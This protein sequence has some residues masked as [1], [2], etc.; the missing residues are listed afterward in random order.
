MVFKSALT[1]PGRLALVAR[2]IKIEHSVFALPF[3]Y[4]GCLWAAGGWPG[5]RVFIALTVAMVA[6][7]SVAMTVNRV[8][9][10]KFDRQNPRTRGRQLVTGEIALH[11][12]WIFILVCAAV[13]VLACAFLNTVCLILSVPAL[14]W[15]SV[16]SLSKRFTWLCHFILGS[17]LGL[18]PIAG[19]IAFDPVWHPAYI[20]LFL[21][22][23]FWVAGFDIL[24]AAQ[25][26]EFDKGVGL[27]SLPSDFGLES[28]FA[29][30]GFCHVNAAL[31]LGLAG[32]LAAA[33]MW[34]FIA[35][36]ITTLIL[37]LEHII[38]S[39]NDLSRINVAFF[40]LNG[41]VSLLLLA[42]VAADTIF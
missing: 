39:P 23:L 35:W 3:A 37:L 34:Y 32:V 40:T 8:A 14:I 1:L 41:V 6:V 38:I 25:D 18:A 4:I 5:W 9:D 29:L 30:S 16:Y 28:A 12:A 27:H 17:V 7:R 19:W 10:L 11:E 42:G 36:G 20:C 15:V 31:F 13:F 21:G 24:Y 26:S 2:M 22:V 33:G